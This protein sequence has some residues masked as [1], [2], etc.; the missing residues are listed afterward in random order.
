VPQRGGKISTTRTNQEVVMK[1]IHRTQVNEQ[2]GLF[3]PARVVQRWEMLPPPA[4]REVVQLL[5]KILADHGRR[6]LKDPAAK[7]EQHNE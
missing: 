6:G 5:E 3:D 7:K 4:R 1:P 2:R